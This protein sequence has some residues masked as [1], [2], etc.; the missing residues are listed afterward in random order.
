MGTSR[1]S[2]RGLM[3]LVVSVCAAIAG[4]TGGANQAPAAAYTWTS[5]SGGNWNDPNWTLLGYPNAA[6]DTA[7][8]SQNITADQV[9]QINVTDATVGS[10]TFGDSTLGA[11]YS[12]WTIGNDGNSNNILTLDNNASLVSPAAIISNNGNNVISAAIALTPQVA[13][14]N[15]ASSYNTITVNGGSLNLAG[16]FTENS[17]GFTANLNS[18]AMLILSGA[19]SNTGNTYTVNGLLR[20]TNGAALSS[21]NLQLVGTILESSDAAFGPSGFTR[22]YGQ[23]AGQYQHGSWANTGFSAVDGNLTVNFGGN[24]TPSQVDWFNTYGTASAGHSRIT[25]GSAN[26]TGTVVI[27]NPFLLTTVASGAANRYFTVLAG[28]GSV[29][30]GEIQGDLSQTPGA[31]GSVIIGTNNSGNPSMYGTVVFSGNNTYTGSTQISHGTLRIAGANALGSGNLYLGG[32]SGQP[33][34]YSRGVIEGNNGG[35]SFGP[36]GITRVIGS[37]A[38]QVTFDTTANGNGGG[39][40]AYGTTATA[41]DNLTVNLGNGAVLTWGNTG[42]NMP[43]LVFGSRLANAT[44]LFMNPIALGSSSRIINVI[45]GVGTGPEVDFR[46][47]LSGTGG[48]SKSTYGLDAGFQANTGTLWLSAANTN[49]GTTS[50]GAGVV[51]LNHALAVQSSLVT[52]GVA[53]GLAFSPGIGTFTMGGLNGS[54]NISNFAL[55][56]TSNAAVTLQIGNNT[57]TTTYS[58]TMS[59]AGGLTKIGGGT[60]TLNGTNTFTGATTVNGGTL[61]L[62][63]NTAALGLNDNIVAT[64]SAL[65]LGGGTLQI[66]GRAGST[67]T[68]TF[69]GLTIN[70]GGSGLT[71]TP[72]SSSTVTANIG[73]TNWARNGN[74]TLNVNIAT[75]G[76]KTINT[77]LT[78]AAQSTST[79]IIPH[80]MVNDGSPGFGYIDATGRLVRY[81]QALSNVP[82]SGSNPTINYGIPSGGTI[83]LTGDSTVRSITILG[84]SAFT[85]TINMGGRKLSIASGGIAMVGSGVNLNI[86]GTGQLGD[87]NAELII[88]GFTA[89]ANLTTI[90]SGVTIGGGTSSLTKAGTNIVVINSANTFTGATTING[91]AIRLGNANSLQNSPVTLWAGNGLTFAPLIGSFKTGGLSGTG[92]LA[93]TDTGTVAVALELAGATTGDYTYRGVLSGTGSSIVKSTGGRQVLTGTNTFTGGSNVSG[94]TLV[95]DSNAALGTGLAQVTSAGTLEIATGRT[96]TNAITLNGSGATLRVNGTTQTGALT[97]TAGKVMGSGTIAQAVTIGSGLTIAPGN[98]V[99]TLSTGNLAITAGGVFTAEADLSTNLSGT[100]YSSDRINV[101]GSVTLGGNLVLDLLDNPTGLVDKTIVLIANDLSDTVNG[102]FAN[103]FP[104]SAGLPGLTYSVGYN[105]DTVSGLY[106]SGNDVAVTFQAV[107]EPSS[108]GLVLAGAAMI[109]RRRRRVN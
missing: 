93:L 32:F 54:A 4:V 66:V 61:A 3:A 109:L 75:A 19:T 80:V 39:F 26:A 73:G 65:A 98:S 55:A 47:V 89:V 102:T 31:V 8:I 28:S 103:V 100:L 6:G 59:G 11:G 101:T 20:V 71:L 17:G 42:F 41:A 72:T 63:F 25:L 49:T 10:L 64:S 5:P 24:V 78:G 43:A 16:G 58:G 14:E 84:G 36:N 76:T 15:A 56:D 74:G 70:A 52:V 1:K 44:V 62:N 83:T 95:A 12:N 105:F 50:I 30:E 57:T 27:K 18:N 29:P 68:Q 51:Q 7:T 85:E 23:G 99:G 22:S 34:Q 69:S 35:D 81:T 38:G 104:G 87:N 60:S 94:G 86:N 88:Q 107:P 37:G 79:A 46:G 48:I 82:A 2:N 45:D 13:P 33:M 77:G 90:A 67:N 40:S 21:G 106:G 91:G 97:L 53:N 96:V 92:N 108:L 9:L